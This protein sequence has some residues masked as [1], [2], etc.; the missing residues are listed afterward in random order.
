MAP[1]F[2]AAYPNLQTYLLIHAK[3]PK[4]TGRMMTT[5]DMIQ[6]TVLDGQH[7][8][9]IQ[10]D[11]W[12][13]PQTYS[14]GTFDDAEA[15]EQEEHG[16]NHAID[17]YAPPRAA[18]RST[19]FSNATRRTYN[20]AIVTT[21]EFHDANGGTVAA[22]TAVVVSSVN[23]IQAIYD[24]ELS[25]RF[26]LLTPLIYTDFNTDPFVSSA[27]RFNDAADVVAL[28]FSTSAY[29]IGHVFH[30]QNQAPAA[31]GTGGVAYIGAVCRSTLVGSGS[32][33]KGGGWSSS[34]DNVSASWIRLAS[35]EFGHM[36][37]AN[38][39][40][41]GSG[42]N[43][44]AS[45]ISSA[46]SYEIGSGTTIMSYRGICGA[47]QNIASSGTNDDY[48]HT[49]SLDEMVSYLTTFATCAT[50]T[51]TGNSAPVANANPTGMTYTIPGETPFLLTGSATD[52]DGDNLTY[53][54]EQ[55]DEDGAGTPTQGFLG[56][57]AASS[58]IAP[59]F[60]SY[61]PKGSPIRVFPEISNIQAGTNTGL[62]FEALPSVSRTMNF[63][64]TVRDNNP[65]GGGINCAA[66]SVVVDGTTGPFVVTSQN[67]VTNWISDGTSTA[68]I[69][70]DV[71]GTTGGA[72]NA[73]TVDILFSLDGGNTFPHTLAAATTNDGS[74]IITIPNYPTFYGRIKIQGTDNIF[75][76]IN[77]ADIVLA[78]NCGAAGNSIAP[79]T[80]VSEPV[81]D[82]DLNLSLAP[83]YGSL[84][85]TFT[86]N[87]DSGDP[88]STLA[89]DNS[90]TGCVNL[91]GN[92]TV[93]ETHSFWVDELDNYTLAITGAFGLVGNIYLGDF[94]PA[95]P[96]TNWLAS[97]GVYNSGTGST[98]LFGGVILTLGPGV[99]YTLV[100]SNFSTTTPTL[101]A[102]YSVTA[103]SAGTGATYS[104]Q[105]D[106]GA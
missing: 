36:F 33:I 99:K 14:I 91:T 102:A 98:T 30:D 96:C 16:C 32:P 72:V 59:L 87:L 34:F 24:R 84:N 29:D 97:T 23:G 41:N 47:G 74:H 39:T 89:A 38:H 37:G 11:D 105:P 77:N 75:F 17:R 21:G 90:G 48:F 9:L 19:G 58:A 44:N 22:A 83:G 55:M 40:F 73:A 28:N 52:A 101:P 62:T 27:A 95:N 60:R 57:A 63:A 64:L 106:P 100:I 31:L 61:P 104:A 94:D 78:S 56:T 49:N 26:N 71:A 45:N 8:S 93:Y 6:V 2:Q 46:N 88:G 80:A 15:M 10:P 67:A 4:I 81:G 86:G 76:D 69:T 43:C 70:W 18:T 35:H 92:L 5:P 20:L 51:N 68:T 50:T 53:T 13:N 85:P 25:V 66:T 7:I 12:K 79:A 1:D 103:T 3:N 65:N 42:S 54:W 82:L